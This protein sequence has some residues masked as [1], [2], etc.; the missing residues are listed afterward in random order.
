MRITAQQNRRK[1]GKTEHPIPVKSS[2]MRQPMAQISTA[3][4]YLSP[5]AQHDQPPCQQQG[6]STR[7]AAGSGCIGSRITSPHHG[8]TQR[9]CCNTWLHSVRWSMV[10]HRGCAVTPGFTLVTHVPMRSSGARYHRVETY[11][12]HNAEVGPAGRAK[13]RRAWGQAG[14]VKECCCAGPG[15]S[16]HSRAAGS[17]SCPGGGGHTGSYRVHQICRK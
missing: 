14:R 2:T 13:P 1:R 17:I 12:L 8:G 3:H 11:A 16:Q 9:L 4:P 5:T 10:A 15:S 7:V 6:S